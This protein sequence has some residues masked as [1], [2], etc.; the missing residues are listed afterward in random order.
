MEKFL[1]KLEKVILFISGIL[2]I[3]MIAA[4][5]WQVILRYGFKSANAWCEELARYS[6][7]CIVM[8]TAP[9]GLRRGRHVRV[10]TFVE[11]MPKSVQAFLDVLM[12]ILMMVYTVGLFVGC[13]TLIG[14]PSKQYSPGLHLDQAYLYGMIAFG[15]ILMI[16][17]MLD[18]IYQKYIKPRKANKDKDGE[19]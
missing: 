8:L 13:S 3:V 12:D 1:N 14:N 17:Y 11:M 2:I 6:L 18:T 16:I 5:A 15:C 10:D 19:V 4:I 7:L 9:I